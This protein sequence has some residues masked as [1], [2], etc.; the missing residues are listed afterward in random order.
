[1]KRIPSTFVPILAGVLAIGTTGCP[2]LFSGLSVLDGVVGNIGNTGNTGDNTD[3]T[4][5]NNGDNN[6]TNDD[7]SATKTSITCHVQ[8]MVRAGEDL[9]A[10]GTGGAKGVSY[11]VPSGSDAAGRTIPNSSTFNSY[12]LA[13]GGRNIFLTDGNF[14]VTVFNADT[15][16]QT[17]IALT[18][19]RLK[20]IPASQLDSGHIQA[21]GSYCAVI[22]EESEVTDSAVIKVIDVSTGLPSVISFTN[23]PI[24]NGEQVQMVAVDSTTRRVVAATSDAFYVFDINSPTAA[25]SQFDADISSVGST[26]MQFDGTHVIFHD[27]AGVPSARLLNVTTGAITALAQNPSSGRSLALRDGNFGYF[28]NRVSSDSVGSHGRTGIGSITGASI[29]LAADDDFIDGSTANN[30]QFGFGQSICITPDGSSFFLAGS[31]NVGS[32]EYL[33]V[34]TGGAFATIADPSGDDELGCPATDVFCGDD[35]LAF[36]TGSGSD[37]VIGYV[38]LNATTVTS[39]SSAQR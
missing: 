34:S 7:F 13:V 8:S 20:N 21:D 9:I 11:I 22:C 5:D 33:Q 17:P 10:F 3:N 18:D 4:D 1:M 14:Q 6:N 15:Q 30:G 27:D 19:I 36:K 31:E 25:P 23:S 39:S 35:V 16:D 29:T 37:T 24:S 28:V 38:R 26:Q 2:E 32:G 12:S